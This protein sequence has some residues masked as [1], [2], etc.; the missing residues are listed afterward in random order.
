VQDELPASLRIVNGGKWVAIEM[1]K[2]P[3]PPLPLVGGGIMHPEGIT[4]VYGR[5][6]IGKGWIACYA[7]RAL[8]EEGLRP[9]V[10]DF[11][12]FSYEWMQRVYWM[13]IRETDGVGY[14]Y[15]DTPL[16]M[17]VSNELG[18]VLETGG[19]TH[20]ILDSVSM[21][22]KIAKDNDS[23]GADAASE[24]FRAVGRMGK[25]ALM[26]AHEAK[27][28]AG[29]IGSVQY[30]NLSR[31]V[32][33]A[34]QSDKAVVQIEME[35][36][37]DRPRVGDMLFRWVSLPEGADFVRA[38]VAKMPEK[39]AAEE[40]LSVS[41]V[42]ILKY[43]ERSLDREQMQRLL[44]DEGREVDLVKVG[45]LMRKLY[46]TGRLVRVDRGRYAFPQAEQTSV[47]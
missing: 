33:H 31:L 26:L 5:G 35:K 15:V 40:S 20:V 9:C 8:V 22:R 45:T 42:R 19:Y 11:E 23:G 38:G 6:G 4:I 28:S 21:A 16:S 39:E 37:N 43:E 30:T 34:S 25:P 47:P 36:A 2:Q 7:I 44:A 27:R 14:I 12:G 1:G 24:L 13:G 41:I 32:W 18:Y 17:P 46:M 10:L 3:S 29:P